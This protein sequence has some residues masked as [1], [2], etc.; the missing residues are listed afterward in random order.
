ME[1]RTVVATILASTHALQSEKVTIY[2][3]DGPPV[4][5]GLDYSSA[6]QLVTKLAWRL[7]NAD[8][9]IREMELQAESKSIRREL[10][11]EFNLR[12]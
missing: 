12:D 10:A 3:D 6:T 11:E 4:T 2:R 8:E 1:L 9:R 5:G 7:I